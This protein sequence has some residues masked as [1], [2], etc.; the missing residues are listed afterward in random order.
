MSDSPFRLF[1]LTISV[2]LPREAPLPE[3]FNDWLVRA[4]G[5]EAVNEMGALTTTLQ[6]VVE[7]RYPL[8]EDVVERRR[9]TT[10]P[11]YA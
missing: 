3:T 6:G 4:F 11:R 9:G 1:D 7:R 2:Y 10:R 5:R 8:A